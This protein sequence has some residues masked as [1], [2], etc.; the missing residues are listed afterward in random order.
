MLKPASRFAPYAVAALLTACAVGPDFKPPVTPAPA[1]FT[2]Q[3]L[4]QPSGTL[5]APG[6]TIP[7]AW[8]QAYGAPQLDVLVEMALRH[9]PNLEAALA[10]LKAAQENVNAQ[11]GLFFPTVSAGYNLNRQSTGAALS[12]PLASGSSPYTLHTAQLNVA[13]QPDLLGGNR[14][15]V[16]SLQAQADSQRLQLDAAR[17]TLASNV[18]GAAL[19]QAALE[20]QISLVQQT[21]S[22]SERQLAHLHRLK[23]SGYSSGVDLATQEAAD[24]QTRALLPPLQKQLEQTRDLLAILCGQTPD[25]V[26]TTPKLAQLQLP[27][28]LPQSLPSQLVAQRPDV[29]AALA[30]L[31]AAQAQ[32]GV[33]VAARLP[34]ISLTGALGFNN[35]ALAGLLARDNLGWGLGAG[36]LQ[37]IFDA[38]TLQARQRS[39]EA[40]ADAARAQYQSTVLGAFQNVADTLYALDADQRAW[41][42]N[43][44]AENADERL[45]KL[46]QAQF[47]RGYASGLALLA[48]QQTWLQ[49]RLA[50]VA[51]YSSYLGD[52]VAL[53][54]ALG[55]GWQAP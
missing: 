3:P 15:Q 12:S 28:P 8:W 40:S 55:G 18:V 51:A 46:T 6:S 39:A 27:Q 35:S 47:D 54:Q 42:A 41:Q 13:Y 5:A 26:L 2:R 7:R 30:Q 1:A 49:A 33:A 31:H 52:T 23:D 4:Q 14:R 24:A 22:A 34:Q 38:G 50:R 43:V 45:L 36:L 48:V 53:Y 17:L 25:Q 29:Q 37:P 9:N 20:E 11:K 10:S 44:D 32:I 19:Q 16:E 21:L